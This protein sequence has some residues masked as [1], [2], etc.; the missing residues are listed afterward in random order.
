MNEKTTINV[1]VHQDA[2]TDLTN[3]T[4]NGTQDLPTEYPSKEWYDKQR[5]KFIERLQK[6][7]EQEFERTHDVIMN[8]GKMK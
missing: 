5:E 4:I 2:P 1:D 3:V 6:A 7:S 8:I